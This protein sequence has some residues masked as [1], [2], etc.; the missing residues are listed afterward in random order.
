MKP[1][2]SRT[3]NAGV[4]RVEHVMGMPISLA[5]RGRH[6]DDQPA[7]TAWAEA[8]AILRNVD[9]VFSTYR[10]DSWISRLQRGEAAVEDSPAEVAEVLALGEQARTESGGAFDV[11]RREANGR[12]VLDPSGVVKGWAVERAAHALITLPDTDFC[13]S[14]G[15]DMVCR[16][17]DPES[18]AWRVG[19]EDPHDWNRLIAVVPVRDGAVATSGVNRRGNH[20]VDARTGATPDVL[21]SVTVIHDSLTWADIDATAAFA[22]GRD[23][24]TWLSTR[25]G[26]KGLVSWQDGTRQLYG[27]TPGKAYVP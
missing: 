3:A 8:I 19:I 18:P 12:L 17:V 10:P 16:V 2:A 13:L 22:L 15:G 11:R 7:R 24:L 4:R 14:A 6:T 9:Q 1:N 25:P 21:A 5:L 27:G 26:R 23:G 20:I